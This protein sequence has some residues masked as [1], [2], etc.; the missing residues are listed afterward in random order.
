MPSDVFVPVLQYKQENELEIKEK[1]AFLF[2]PHNQ[3][4]TGLNIQVMDCIMKS[5]AP[6]S[7]EHLI[8]SL[9]YFKSS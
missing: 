2:S 3:D 8:I 1:N 4:E 5:K 7:I 6:L 9:P